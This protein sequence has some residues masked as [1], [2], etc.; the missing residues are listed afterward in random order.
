LEK[1][2]DRWNKVKK[3]VNGADEESRLYFHEGDV[4]CAR[5]GV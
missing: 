2:F 5:V 3:A 1:D 4:W